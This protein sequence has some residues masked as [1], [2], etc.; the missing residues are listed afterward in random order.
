MF[1]VQTC[2]VGAYRYQQTIGDGG[3]SSLTTV[4]SQLRTSLQSC[5][6]CGSAAGKYIWLLEKDAVY[7]FN[8]T[9][10]VV[11]NVTA[12]I[13]QATENFFFRLHAQTL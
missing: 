11:Y 8:T 7:I 9:T 5:I 2:K 4:S 1:L 3:F 13:S 6:T 12:D 10:F